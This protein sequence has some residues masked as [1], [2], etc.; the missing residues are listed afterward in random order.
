MQNVDHDAFA[1][2]VLSVKDLYQHGAF[3]PWFFQ[4]N[5][6]TGNP[7][8]LLPYFT[9]FESSPFSLRI[10]LISIMALG[11]VF[12]FLS[13]YHIFD[14]KK[15]FIGIL[16]LFTI[17]SWL[18]FRRADFTYLAVFPVICFYFFVRWDSKRDNI[19]MYF[20][21][22]F[23]GLLFYFKAVVAYIMLSLAISKAIN[24]PQEILKILKD[25]KLREYIIAISLFI[26]GLLPFIAYILQ[27]PYRILSPVDSSS[28]NLIENF[29]IRLSD[30]TSLID[31][32]NAMNTQDPVFLVNSVSILLLVS[33]LVTLIIGKNRDYTI[34]FLLF[35]C[36]LLI[37][38]QGSGMRYGHLFALIPLIPV[39]IISGFE[40]LEEI[41]FIEKYDIDKLL[42]LLAIIAISVNIGASTAWMEHMQVLQSEPLPAG[43][44]PAGSADLI[45]ENA[46][47]EKTTVTNSYDGAL[48]ALY[49]FDVEKVIFLAD[50]VKL[51][52]QKEWGYDLGDNPQ[53]NGRDKWNYKLNALDRFGAKVKT[54]ENK[55]L[56]QENVSFI[57]TN[58][59][60]CPPQSCYNSS[61]IQDFY[62]L[63]KLEKSL[64]IEDREYRIYTE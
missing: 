57:I 18:I 6:Y 4:T 28:L 29:K 40:V 60:K 37:L 2:I 43:R 9:L 62:K 59:L 33:I 21:S 15:A 44:A 45:A 38:P 50:E 27:N 16:I 41:D 47:L 17:N 3:E 20:L 63:D 10:A 14:L 46:N 61:Y 12:A 7:F 5:F 49:D 39:I 34:A 26:A 22:F 58:E 30:F 52:G 64:N 23:S 48:Y 56:Q 36:F 13:Y 24:Q 11:S 1:V 31:P 19:S 55:N 42:Y 32:M 51:R 8:F 53:L 35:F 54:P 25:L